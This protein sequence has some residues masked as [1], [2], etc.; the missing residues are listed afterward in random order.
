MPSMQILV[1]GR[2]TEPCQNGSTSKHVPQQKEFN[3]S[4]FL[5]YFNV[6]GVLVV[7]DFNC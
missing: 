6:W 7:C 1:G 2:D 3:L 4:P 5:S